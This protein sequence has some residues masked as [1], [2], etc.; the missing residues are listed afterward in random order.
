MTLSYCCPSTTTHTPSG[1]SHVLVYTSITTKSCYGRKYLSP[2]CKGRQKGEIP[3]VLVTRRHK[4]PRPPVYTSPFTKYY[5]PQAPAPIRQP[6]LL[7]PAATARRLKPLFHTHPQPRNEWM[8]EEI[9]SWKLAPTTNVHIKNR[10]AGLT[11]VWRHGTRDRSQDSSS[12]V[13][14]P[15]EGTGLDL[16]WCIVTHWNRKGA[17][18]W[19][20]CSLEDCDRHQTWRL[21]Q[22]QMM[23]RG[24]TA[25]SI[26]G[27]ES[28]CATPYL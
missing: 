12:G 10:W 14:Q 11:K 15:E 21:L 27:V 7:F 17:E 16:L 2:P 8:T 6:F 18:G 13:W 28:K 24:S 3:G 22:L 20:A 25:P 23:W 4:Y 1:F 19:G 9:R 26:R 5:L